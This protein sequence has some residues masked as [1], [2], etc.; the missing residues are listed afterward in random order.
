MATSGQVYVTFSIFYLALHYSDVQAKDSQCLWTAWSPC[1]VTCISRGS[2]SV[3]SQQWQQFICKNLNNN[4][5]II[6]AKFR[7]CTHMIPLC[8]SDEGFSMAFHNYY[9][10]AIFL[11]CILL[12]FFP[13]M[14]LGL[15]YKRVW[16]WKSRKT[17]QKSE[18]SVLSLNEATCR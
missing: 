11:V 18:Q 8:L 12:A 13:N 1:T 3:Y 9:F 6:T 4:S 5:I 10:L 14:I 17:E 7:S 15:R 2:S 16:I